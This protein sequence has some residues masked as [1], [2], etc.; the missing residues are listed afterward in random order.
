MR[1]DG[2]KEGRMDGQTDLAKPIVPFFK[3][4]NEPNK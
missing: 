3:P 1:T 4:A 2:K